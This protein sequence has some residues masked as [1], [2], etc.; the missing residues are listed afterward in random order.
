MAMVVDKRV[1]RYSNHSSTAA[2]V[3]QV[4]F[5]DLVSSIEVLDTTSSDVINGNTANISLKG[6]EGRLLLLNFEP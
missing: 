1:S 6:G 3:V 2:R 5:S 4:T